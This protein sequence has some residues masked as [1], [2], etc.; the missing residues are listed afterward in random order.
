MSQWYDR[1]FALAPGQRI[2]SGFLVCLGGKPVAKTNS[3]ESAF[4]LASQMREISPDGDFSIYEVETGIHLD[5]P[6][7]RF[8]PPHDPWEAFDDLDR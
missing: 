6:D 5:R 1:N 3:R 7:F 8:M 4:E 2:A